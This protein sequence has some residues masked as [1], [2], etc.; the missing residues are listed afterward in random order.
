MLAYNKKNP[1][2]PLH[3]HVEPIFPLTVAMLQLKEKLALHEGEVEKN[4]FFFLITRSFQVELIH[5]R[6]IA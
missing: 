5:C 2:P 1:F 3:P 6:N 4:I